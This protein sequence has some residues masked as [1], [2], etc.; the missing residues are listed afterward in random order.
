MAHQGSQTSIMKVKVNPS[1]Q[2]QDQHM[3]HGLQRRV[4]CKLL[5]H[6]ASQWQSDFIQAIGMLVNSF[7]RH[8]WRGLFTWQQSC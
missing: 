8:A 1:Q 6:I 7:L 2:V 5:L 4:M 3:K